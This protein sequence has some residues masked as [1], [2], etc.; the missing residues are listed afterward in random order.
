MRTEIV[1]RIHR[2][3]RPDSKTYVQEFRVPYR[4]RLNLIACLQEVARNPVDAAGRSVAPPAWDANC[5]EEVCGSCTVLVNGKPRQAC[6]TLVDSLPEGPVDLAPLSRFPVLRDL[7]VDRSTMFESLKRI[8]GW[9]PIQG[10]YD[11][12]PG[13][14]RSPAEQAEAYVF[15]RCMTCGCCMEACP[16]FSGEDPGQFIG[17]APLGQA[18]YFLLHPT[19]RMQEGE[20]LDRLMSRGGIAGCGNAQ[21][22][23]AVCPKEIPLTE[24]IAKLNRKV[25]RHWLARMFAR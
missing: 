10:T 7:V 5:L 11:L 6:S 1:L 18:Y 17:P 21:N 15:S 2:Q 25:N 20:R 19:G 4:P 14:K 24:A 3:D 23:Y 12:G 9:V 13:P 16:N 22:C 8:Q